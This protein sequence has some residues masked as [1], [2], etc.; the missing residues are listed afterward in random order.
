MGWHV[1]STDVMAVSICNC[2]VTGK[3]THKTFLHGE[4]KECH[5]YEKYQEVYT[6]WDIPGDI[7][8]SASNYW[9]WFTAQF[10]Q[11]LA[12]EYKLQPG[13]VP[14]DW[15]QINWADVKREEEAVFK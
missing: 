4:K 14:D 3:D 1:Q 15:K 7:S 12:E 9:K 11:N 10:M 6:E 5:E 2:L 8:A 13:P